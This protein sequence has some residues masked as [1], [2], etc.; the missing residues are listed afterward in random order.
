[1]AGKTSEPFQAKLFEIGEGRTLIS[2]RVVPM[3][4]HL[5]IGISGGDEHIGAVALAEPYPSREN[6][7]EHH[8]SVSLLTRTGHKETPIAECIARKLASLLKFPVLVCCGIHQDEI[9]SSEIREI[10]KNS[11]ILLENMIDCLCRDGQ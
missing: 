11:E 4:N 7:D 2:A 8:A 1:M 10:E 5:M 3:G 6:P 9:T